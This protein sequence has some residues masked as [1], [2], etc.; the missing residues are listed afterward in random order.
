MKKSKQL[1]FVLLLTGFLILSAQVYGQASLAGENIIDT[2]EID[3]TLYTCVRD[4]MK[5]DQWYYIPNSPRLVENK[6]DGKMVP[7]FTLV[8]F[9]YKEGT[10]FVEGG[11]LQFE[12]NMALP[13]KVVGK[14]KDKVAKY[15]DEKARNIRLGA[16]PFSKARVHVY[17]PLGELFVSAT[18]TEGIAPNIATGSIPFSIRLEGA[19]AA[20]IMSALVEKGQGGVPVVIDFEYSGITPPV[21]GLYATVDMKKMYKHFEKNEKS[22]WK[23]GGWFWSASR[24]RD[25]TTIREVIKASGS[26]KFSILQSDDP[27]V[28]ENMDSFQGWIMEQIAKDLLVLD[29]P[30]PKFDPAKAETPGSGWFGGGGS[31][32]SIRDVRQDIL[33]NK[34]YSAEV[35]RTVTRHSSGGALI[36]IGTYSEDIRNQLVFDVPKGVWDKVFYTMPS[37]T[38][39]PSVGIK[40][41][42][43]EID[44]KTNKGYKERDAAQYDPDLG[45]WTYGD[46]YVSMMSWGLKGLAAANEQKE[47]KIHT[48]MTVTAKNRYASGPDTRIFESEIPAFDGK[49]FVAMPTDSMYAY[50]IFA[51]SLSFNVVDPDSNLTAVSIMMTVKDAAGKTKRVRFLVR[52]TTRDPYVDPIGFL[53]P[54]DAREVKA[55]ISF[56][57]KGA[58]A[59]QWSY[60][61]KNLIGS[62]YDGWLFLDD[63][64]WQ[65]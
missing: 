25:I 46:D 63:S 36:G 27:K 37:V 59:V 6:I 10:R 64:M 17:S 65:E 1:A 47:L 41:V 50:M 12:V 30:P 18:P 60:N 40:T 32:V 2:I 54:E 55:A 11:V 22:R 20:D 26:V 52:P 49:S 3:G 42:K 8:R 21:A 57:R 53:V 31:S 34:K 16:L 56:Q 4:A 19:A 62:E 9:Q 7:K 33:V 38:A 13:P 29:T 23:V 43:L 45:S 61:G 28:Q 48:K 35:R 5:E 14:L 24:T 39:D 51:D 44:I 58:R 15:I